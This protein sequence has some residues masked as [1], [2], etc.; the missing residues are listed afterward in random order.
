MASVSAT[1]PRG[2]TIGYRGRLCLKKFVY[3]M[4]KKRFVLRYAFRN[5]FTRGKHFLFRSGNVK[6]KFAEKEKL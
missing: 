5:M 4:C 6:E 2:R 3:Q 1:A